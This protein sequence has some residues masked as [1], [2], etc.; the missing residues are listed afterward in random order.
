M[1]DV[2]EINDP[3][4]LEQFRLVWSAL[5]PKTP[6]GSFFHTLDWLQTYW[7]YFGQDQRL[8]VL[9]IR[10]SGIPI[11]I[12]P[13]CV[14]RERYRI[15]NVRVLTYPLNDWGMWYGPLGADQAACMFMALKHI[16]KTPRDWDMLDLRWTAA[17]PGDHD[18]TGQTL[19]ALGWQPHQ[20]AYQTNSILGFADT[21]YE[22]YMANRSKK[23]R[24][25][26][27]RQARAL[28]R[29]GKVSFERYR[30][31]GVAHGD[32][33]P[34][35]D[36][37]ES[38][39]NLS[40]QS[41]QG[42]STTGNTLCHQRVRNFLQD[43]HAVA[44]K[45]GMLDVAVL[46]LNGTPTAFQYNYHYHGRVY[47]LRMGYDREYSK[48]G[49]GKVL[50]NRMIEDSFQRGDQLLDLGAGDYDFKRRCRTEVETSFRFACYP[51]PTWKS[52]GVRLTNW[53]KERR[54]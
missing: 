1:A 34:A 47:G 30:P 10:S 45:L 2:I 8:R 18:S 22:T 3:D 23:W 42:G 31:A 48:V 38:C 44:A 43:C 5:L 33:E 29:L 14:R 19:R 53:L 46:K 25:E 35:W 50:L 27:R 40:R 51:W 24:H 4:Q 7:K 36:I 15:G 26:V 37:Y 16:S 41:W 54:A 9:V 13:L 12:V 39:L 17:E 6:R 21:D 20:S 32:G 49:V 11:G 28:A 52:Q